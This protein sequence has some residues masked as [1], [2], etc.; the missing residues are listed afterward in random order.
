MLDDSLEFGVFTHDSAGGGSFHTSQSRQSDWQDRFEVESLEI[1]G[2]GGD[3]EAEKQRAAWAFEEREAMMRRNLNIGKDVEADRALLE[4]AGLIGQHNA[5]GE[6][7]MN[8]TT[9]DETDS[10]SLTRALGLQTLGH[11]CFHLRFSLEDSGETF[12]SSLCY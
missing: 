2:C 5:S 10:L 7:G 12:S 1:W 4:M 3:E 11:D 9:C 6:Y 8:P